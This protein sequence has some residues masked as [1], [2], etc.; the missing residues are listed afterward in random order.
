[1]IDKMLLRI[2]LKGFVQALR[3]N[4]LTEISFE[5]AL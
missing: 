4:I 3:E 5:D 1:M 2:C